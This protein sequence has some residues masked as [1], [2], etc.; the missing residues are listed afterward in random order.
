[1]DRHSPSRSKMH[2]VRT[3]GD[4]KVHLHPYPSRPQSNRKEPIATDRERRISSTGHRH[5]GRNRSRDGAFRLLG[6]LPDWLATCCSIV[7]GKSGF[8]AC[9]REGH[10]GRGVKQKS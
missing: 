4:C 10:Q 2:R 7:L 9:R 5:P 6:C 3:P 1:M 8:C